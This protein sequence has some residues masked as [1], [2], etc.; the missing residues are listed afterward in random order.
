MNTDKKIVYLHPKIKSPDGGIGRRASF[1][2]Q[3]PQ[4]CAGS[5][6]VPGTKAEELLKLPPFSF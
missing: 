3:C 5:S 1:R 4:G 2:D 6:P